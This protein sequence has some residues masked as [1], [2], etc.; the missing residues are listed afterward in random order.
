MDASYQ[1]CEPI[2]SRGGRS[3]WRSIVPT[4]LRNSGPATV[5]R[6]SSATV[7]AAG[8]FC[9]GHESQTPAAVDSRADEQGHWR[10][11]VVPN[12]YPAVMPQHDEHDTKSAVGAHEVIIES[13]RHVDR[14]SSLTVPEFSDVLAVYA[15][16][17][18]PLARRRR[19]RVWLGVQKRGS[20]GRG[21]LSHLHSQLI[22]LPKLPPT[23]AAE[24]Q[25]AEQH[26][27][28]NATC[29]LLR[30]DCDRTGGG[31]TGRVRPR[32]LHRLL[33][34]REPAALRSLDAADRAMSP[35]L[36]GVQMPRLPI[37]LPRCSIRFWRGSKR[38]CRRRHT[39]CSFALHLG[40][41]RLLTAVI[42]ESRSCRE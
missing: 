35:G 13:A 28:K 32:R 34:L 24:C 14:T 11:R 23:V 10:V 41:R 38:F 33:P 3:F 20:L 42:G 19:F 22:A 1:N 29:A 5:L 7:A 31:R 15:A 12:M 27:A 37:D 17:L 26:Y 21:L 8:P 16:R 9:P 25:R 6:A 18:G 4:G 40:N 30:S 39:T 36:S 2:G